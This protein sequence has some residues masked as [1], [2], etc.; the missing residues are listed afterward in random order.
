MKRVMKEEALQ[1]NSF[2]SQN[3]REKTGTL[4]IPYSLGLMNSDCLYING[5]DKKA[6]LHIPRNLSWQLRFI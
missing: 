6:I 3:F 2:K 1:E 5:K 4:E